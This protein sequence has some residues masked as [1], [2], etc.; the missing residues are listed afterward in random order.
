MTQFSEKTR[1]QIE[2][3]CSKYRVKE[4]SLF[5]SRARGDNRGDSDYDLLVD[6]LPDAGIDLFDYAEM[7]NDLEDLLGKDVDL[8]SKPGLKKRI[9]SRVLAEAKEIYAR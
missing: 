7:K 1:Q 5:G 4:L 9:R 6:F 8:V 3:L 2:K